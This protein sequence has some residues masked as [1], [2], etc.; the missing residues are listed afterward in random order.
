MIDI[1][2]IKSVHP[3]SFQSRNV[4]SHTQK[5]PGTKK[6][7]SVLDNNHSASYSQRQAQHRIRSLDIDRYPINDRKI[8]PNTGSNNAQRQNK[9]DERSA[10]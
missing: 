7:V 10:A 1:K 5:L 8:L 6:Q 3:A 2:E 9:S 4:K